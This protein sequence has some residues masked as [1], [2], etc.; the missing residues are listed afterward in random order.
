MG[1]LLTETSDPLRV[2]LYGEGG[3]GK[4]SAL[5]GMAHLGKVLVINAEKGVKARALRK[6]G[7][8]VENIEVFPGDNETLTYDTFE[9]EIQRVADALSKDVNSYAG[10]VWDSATE[11]MAALLDQAVAAAYAKAQRLGKARE[12]H[13]IALEDYGTV[14][15]QLRQLIRQCMDL[16]CHFGVSALARREQ[17]DDGTVKYIINVTPA[18]RKDLIGWMDMVGFCDTVTVGEDDVYRGLFR[19]RG[20]YYGKDRLNATP[21]RLMDP[22]FDRLLG[23]V[24][25]DLEVDTD[26]VME[27]VRRAISK[28]EKDAAP[29][30]PAT[31]AETTNPAQE[32]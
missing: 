2:L 31:S 27:R 4:T 12:K 25:G 15:T 32:K 16:P 23:Y 20:K 30:A 28:I 19:P 8:P 11:V 6:L 21:P 29:A 9:A 22:S 17:D 5:L 1:T 26:P 14:T 7:I 10:I 3:A 18:F 13:F 24:E